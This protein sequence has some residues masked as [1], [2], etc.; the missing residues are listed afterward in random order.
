[1]AFKHFLLGSH[2]FMVTAFGSCVKWPLDID[3]EV[4]TCIF[5]FIKTNV[6]N[7]VMEA[8]LA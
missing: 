4:A 7:T 2:N 5:L 1:M 3:M 8:T 6:L